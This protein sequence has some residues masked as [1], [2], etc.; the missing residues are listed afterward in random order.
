VCATEFG[1][2]LGLLRVFCHA[3]GW[4]TRAYT[5]LALPFYFGVLAIPG[6]VA[7]V[8]ASA[9]WLHATPARWRSEGAGRP[10][11]AARVSVHLVGGA[12]V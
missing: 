1:R 2:Q 5:L 6:H 12:P 7:P 4:W 9:R 10:D 11:R 8:S 3:Y